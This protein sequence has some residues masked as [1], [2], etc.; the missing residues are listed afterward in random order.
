MK[1][2]IILFIVLLTVS[3]FS[4]DG[5][6]DLSFNRPTGAVNGVVNTTFIQPDEKI[7]VGGD[8]TYLNRI[9]SNKIG[10][11]NTNGTI[12][13]TFICGLGF[14][15]TVNSINLQSNGKILVV[16]N[17]TL[18]NGTLKNRII[19]LNEDGTVDTTFNIGTGA[20]DNIYSTAIQTDGKIIVVGN[21][22]SFNDNPQN[23]I[24]RLNVDGSIDST[25]NI[26]TGA[27][28]RIESCVIQPDGKIIVAGSFTFFNGIAKKRIIRLNIDGTFESTFNSSNTT[29]ASIRVVKLQ[30]DG[31]ILIGGLFTT[32]NGISSNFLVRLNSDSTVD[33][34]FN[35]GSGFDN[36]VYTI[37]IQTDGKL[38]VGGVFNS[39]NNILNT[40][41]I[42][43][44]NIDGA[45]DTIFSSN[46]STNN[47]F[48]PYVNVNSTSI[49]S[50]GKIVIGGNFSNV[51]GFSRNNLVDLNSSGTVNNDFF[52]FTENGVSTNGDVRAIS[53]QTDGKI[54]I[55]GSGFNSYNGFSANSIARL[56]SD[57]TL[58]STFNFGTGFDNLINK[59]VV[60]SNNKII[61]VGQFTI[62][63]GITTKFIAQ[64][65]SDGTL[66]TSFNASGLGA[67]GIIY[68]VSIQTNGKI[69]IGGDFTKY[70][71]VNRY[72][73]AR[74]N[75]NGTLDT[76][77][78]TLS[79]LYSSVR[80]TEIQP[81]GK[82]VFGGLF[83]NGSLARYNINGT[84]DTTFNVGGAGANYFVYDISIQNDGKLIVVGDFT[85][86]NNVTV[87]RLTR[88]NVNGSIDASFNFNGS[89]TNIYS[90]A[91]QND[92][93]IIANNLQRLNIDGTIDNSF[94][95][96]SGFNSYINALV[97]QSDG[98]ILCGGG[99]TQYNGYFL[100]SN[101]ITRLNSSNNLSLENFNSE[102][103]L[104][105]YPNPVNDYLKFN[106]PQDLSVLSFKV[107][108]LLGKKIDSNSIDS[109]S[110]DVTSYSKGFYLLHLKTNKG[111][112]I[113]KFYKN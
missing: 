66:D 90:S 50:N 13:N 104:E 106:L 68:S 49:Q 55:G 59:I 8:F 56:N 45:I 95:S 93:K 103:K 62:Y 5:S 57:G 75:I 53:L 85:M 29:N 98:K 4:Q 32:Y 28:N 86:F 44:L 21:F 46:I 108:D 51:G 15:N 84:I 12:D 92:G 40:K 60:L 48:N 112:F 3:G 17:F 18:Y 101:Y 31:K 70:N 87:N 69:I 110:I 47:T 64:L 11:L 76:T 111:D 77:F 14:N 54:I 24:V 33:T 105:I 34:T 9:A 52:P 26:G 72:G 16:G 67:N 37:N 7:I 63:N 102:I 78:N 82:I 91:I 61:V 113:K 43:R 1:K 94:V 88:L 74:L 73:V 107:Y 42:V 20:N 19:R 38:I 83:Q 99:F 35:L 89:S 41:G 6:V 71:G 96:G 36:S 109:N 80:T 25:F 58:D 97:I 23:R 81:D 10:R 2:F 22:T 65:N 39:C 27:N 79:D 100:Q 30:S